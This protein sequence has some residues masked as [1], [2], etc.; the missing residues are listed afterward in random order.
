MFPP[1]RREGAAPDQLDPFVVS[2]VAAYRGLSVSEMLEVEPREN[3]KEW[4]AF[5]PDEDRVTREQVG[6]YYAESRRPILNELR[7]WTRLGPATYIRWLAIHVARELRA[8]SVFDFGGSVGVVTSAAASAGF[9]RVALFETSREELD[10]ARWRDARLGIPALEYVGSDDVSRYSGQFDFG[11]CFEV[12]EHVWDVEDVVRVL[13]GLLKPGGILM[14][15][16][17]FGLYPHPEHLKKNVGYHDRELALFRGAGF[18]P[19]TIEGIG[20][21]YPKMWFLRKPRGV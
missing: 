5:V 19:I 21:R 11:S 20:I 7:Q 9:P 18:Q 4:K 1:S 16:C 10:F 3:G 6:R 8:Q 17:S 13:Y 12:L 14:L 15:T 2:L